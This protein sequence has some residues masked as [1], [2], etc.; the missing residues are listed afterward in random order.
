M[1]HA[2]WIDEENLLNFCP[3]RKQS[4]KKW[5]EKTHLVCNITSYLEQPLL[6]FH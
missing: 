6:D 3:S 5:N 1:N 4:I 2:K